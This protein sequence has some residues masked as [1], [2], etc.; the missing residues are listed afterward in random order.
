MIDCESETKERI[1]RGRESVV[2]N[3]LI[4]NQAEF[5]DRCAYRDFQAEQVDRTGQCEGGCSEQQMIV[6]KNGTE[7][8]LRTMSPCPWKS[9]VNEFQSWCDAGCPT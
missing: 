7:V 6:T 2:R 3:P 1:K 8:C 4:V 9:W 5:S